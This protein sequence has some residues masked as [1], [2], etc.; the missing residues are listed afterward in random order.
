MPLNVSLL[1][2]YGILLHLYR[3]AKATQSKSALTKESVIATLFAIKDMSD[4]LPGAAVEL[5]D[6]VDSV[7]FP[8]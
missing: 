4:R 6:V 3:V 2:W 5:F 8:T 1:S 7:I